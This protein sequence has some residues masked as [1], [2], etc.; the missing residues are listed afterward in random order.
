MRQFHSISMKYIGYSFRFSPCFPALPISHILHAVQW[1]KCTYFPC[2]VGMPIPSK[3]PAHPWQDNCDIT[4]TSSL[5]VWDRGRYVAS[6]P[7]TRSAVK[8]GRRE[9]YRASKQQ[10][11]QLTTS[12]TRTAGSWQQMQRRRPAIVHL[13]TQQQR[14]QLGL[15]IPLAPINS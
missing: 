15:V 2:K 13:G 4:Y 7:P 11:Q 12:R 9:I 8:S 1:T 14:A 6:V 3:F 5:R 10:Q